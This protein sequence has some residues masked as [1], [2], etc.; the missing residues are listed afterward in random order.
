VSALALIPPAPPSPAPSSDEILGRFLDH[1]AALGLEL[2][3]AQEEAVFEILAGKHVILST[4]TGSGK[5][6]VATAFLWKALAEG[7]RGFWSCPVKALVNEKFFDLCGVFGP[8]RVGLMTGDAT[9]NREAPI[10]CG[11]AEILAQMCLRSAGPPADAIVMDE[12]HYYADR[13]RGIAWQLPLITL[14]ESTFLLMSATLG[15]TRAIERSL[16][17]RTGR[18]V[19]VVRGMTRP[20]PLELSYRETP[21]HETIAEL[22]REGRAP[23][24]LVNFTQ[25][26]AAEE[27]QNLTSVDFCTKEEKEA[28]KEALH[29]TGERFASPYGKELQRLLRH[30]LGLHHAGLLPRY[31]RLVERLAQKGLLKVISGTDT[32]GVGVN[33]PIRTV[34]FTQLCKF[35]GEKDAILSVREFHQIAGRAGRKGFDDRGTV[36]VQAPA[37]VIE[38]KRQAAKAASAGKQAHKVH[39]QKPPGKGFVHWD[40]GTFDRLATGTP[41]PL[42]SR[43]AVT[44]GLLVGVLQAEGH[45]P[46]R[47]GGYRRLLEIIEASHEGPGAKR[48]WKRVAA[49][50]FRTLRRAGL[51]ELRVDERARNPYPVPH[52]SL[53]RDFS[54]HHTLALYLVETLDKL[55]PAAATYPFD[56]L[57]LVEAILENPRPV[58][59]AQLDRLKGELIASWKAEGVDYDERM[60]RLEEVEWPKPNG[61]LIYA[62]FNEFAARHP[63]VGA[64]NIAPKG[65]AAE[66]L[67]RFCGFHDYVRELGIARVEGVLLRYLSETVRTLGQTVPR[68][69]QTPEV[70]EMILTLGGIVRAVDAS[71]LE[72]WE[73]LRDPDAAARAAAARDAAAAEAAEALARRAAADPL[74]ALAADA[75]AFAARARADMHR[76]LGALARRSYEDALEALRSADDGAGG[77][78]TAERLKAALAAFYQ[79]HGGIVTTPAARHPRNT[80]VRPR[81]PRL[82]DVVQRVV[83]PEG[84]DDWAIY[85]RIDLRAPGPV[86]GPL[87]ELERIGP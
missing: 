63:W 13:E 43:F 69:H 74:G 37:H 55:D 58:L 6:L 2:Y 3:P 32:L 19:A 73:A 61:E 31:R 17:E 84:H 40:K 28:I 53:Q 42:E 50:A 51:I 7:R 82:W 71:L 66:L 1:V 11:T 46:R 59:L 86:E 64:E 57:A 20:V 80:A 34:L 45:D 65:V 67:E 10:L 15:D 21:L 56:V 25:R 35:D 47:G 16:A 85:A 29:A 39:K 30:G 60:T 49:Q 18:A 52:P 68:R 83:D 9:V 26:A 36:V 77:V 33:I 12:F 44:H 23:I 4:P 54:L 24:Y 75:R 62:T 14:R 8:E 81:E 79:D 72:E 22:V 48:R 38:N 27:A 5:S 87:I 78:W 41:E 70:E 76:L